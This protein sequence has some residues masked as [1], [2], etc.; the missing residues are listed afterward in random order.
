M[1]RSSHE[2]QV[3]GYYRAAPGCSRLRARLLIPDCRPALTGR[4][5][6]SGA[7]PYIATARLDMAERIAAYP[8]TQAKQAGQTGAFVC[9][10][11][12]RSRSPVEHAAGRID[13][14]RYQR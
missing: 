4:R 2:G 3:A 8:A 13:A 1:Q 14:T 12:G 6:Y 11:S 7:V 9:V 10:G 5:A